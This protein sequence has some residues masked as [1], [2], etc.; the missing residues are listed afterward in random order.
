MC[1]NF[2]YLSLMLQ[3]LKTLEEENDINKITNYF[4]YEHF[5]VIYCKFWELDTDHDLLINSQD[6]A[7]YCDGQ[8]MA[9]NTYALS[10]I[11]FGNSSFNLLVFMDVLQSFCWLL[12]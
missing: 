1:I 7:R 9:T 8:G 11:D 2:M 10:I 5:Y 12:K 6:L 3:V 4:S